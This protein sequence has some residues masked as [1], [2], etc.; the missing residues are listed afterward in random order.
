MTNVGLVQV[1]QR[2][3]KQ[4]KKLPTNGIGVALLKAIK[5]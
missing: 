3:E 5:G 4:E 2:Y 1:I